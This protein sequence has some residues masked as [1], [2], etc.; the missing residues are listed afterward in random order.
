MIAEFKDLTSYN[1]GRNGAVAYE[2]GAV[3]FHDFR[4]ANNVRANIE[5]GFVDEG[6]EDDYAKVVG[7]WILGKSAYWT[8]D[9][10]DV[11]SPDGIVFARSENFSIEG[12]KF[13]YYEAAYDAAALATCQDCSEMVDDRNIGAY[14]TKLTNL[15]YDVDNVDFRIRFHP[16]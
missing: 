5:Y 10:L 3:Q 8:S 2:V 15:W 11:A 12:T 13:C 9:R 6:I 7:G 1:N 16:E 4:S 14:T